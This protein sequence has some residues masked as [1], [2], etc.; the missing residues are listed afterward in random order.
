MKPIKKNLIQ[1]VLWLM[2]G[3]VPQLAWAEVPNVINYQ[4]YLTDSSGD[5][6]EG[7]VNVTLTFWN[8]LSGGT[9]IGSPK[10]YTNVN[11]NNGV[12]SQNVNV[13][14]IT[15][16]QSVY[17]ETTV[18][19]ETLAPR[20]L[21]TSVPTSHLTKQAEQDQDTLAGLNCAKDQI[22]KW[23]SST[24]TCADQ[25]QGSQNGSKLP[26]PDY[27]SGWFTMKSQ[28]GTASF[29]E[30]THG[31]GVYPSLVKVLV[32]AVD[33]ENNGFIFEGMGSA[34]NDDDTKLTHHGGVIFAYNDWQVRLWAPDKNNNYKLGRIINVYDGWGGEM[35]TQQS[36]EALVKVKAWK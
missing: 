11:V 26:A 17:V 6:L 32:K 13:S 20:Q 19:G 28:A 34:Q 3:L 8:A 2:L 14:D 24:W 12:F 10:S 18:N 25:A 35:H 1:A 21:I 22:P 36:T 23:D 9:A 30:L 4:G 16:D 5:P 31:L 33:G 27:D 15:F 29:K 7:T